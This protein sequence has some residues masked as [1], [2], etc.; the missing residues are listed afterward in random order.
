LKPVYVDNFNEVK[1][2]PTVLHATNKDKKT[3]ILKKPRADSQGVIGENSDDSDQES[4][5]V[6]FKERPSVHKF[7]DPDYVP[8]PKV[9]C[10]YACW[11]P[12]AAKP[13]TLRR[14]PRYN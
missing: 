11:N 1:Q 9:G 6:Q 5:H 7:E 8:K 2:L 12:N 13:N 3:G 4:K 14:P 10:W